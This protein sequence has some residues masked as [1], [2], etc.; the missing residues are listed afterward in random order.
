MKTLFRAAFALSALLICSVVGAQA[1]ITFTITATADAN[2]EGYTMGD[3][4]TFS[5]TIGSFG[6]T[7]GSIFYPNKTEW[8]EEHLTDDPL[9]TAIGG[10]GVLGSFVRPSS[11]SNA[12]Y[13]YLHID[14]SDGADDLLSLYPQADNN[15][16]IGLKTLNE[17]PVYFAASLV[18]EGHV[19]TNPGEYAD[20]SAYFADYIGDYD[21]EGGV[22]AYDLDNNTIASFTMSNLTISTVPEPGTYAAIAGVMSLGFVAWRR[23]SVRV[24]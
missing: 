16:D 13:S 8:L 20:P 23:R 15:E 12:P 19:F 3:T 2:G 14:G 17:T 1:Q 11:T 21:V 18:M 24:G 6:P 10:T 7:D 9:F 22:A 4:Y 5:Y